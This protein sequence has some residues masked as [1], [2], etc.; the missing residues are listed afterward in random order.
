MKNFPSKLISW[1]F[2]PLLIPTFAFL[3]F[4]NAPCYLS[5]YPTEITR[6][7]FFIIL[8]FTFS[9]PLL[10]FFIYLNFNK[11]DSLQLPSQKSRTFP[12]I[13]VAI[14]YA[15]N[16]IILWRMSEI[17]PQVISTFYLITFLVVLSNVIINF[18]TKI[19]SHML[20][21]G[22]FIGY[23]FVFH[24]AM[25]IESLVPVLVFILIAVIT[26]SSRLKLNA[27]TPAQ[28]YLGFFVGLSVGL[29]PLFLMINL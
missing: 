4:F 21:L 14:F 6:G 9:A 8:M 16:Y 26:A 1:V 20:A 10:A 18:K 27:H 2:H 17:V 24:F 28:I 13:M 29:S 23:T 12:L 15:V 25:N 5:L 22:G 3:Y 11:I 7:L 19:S